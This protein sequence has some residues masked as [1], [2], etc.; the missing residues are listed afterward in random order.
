MNNQDPK[1]SNLIDIRNYLNQNKES[2]KNYFRESKAHSDQEYD[3]YSE[4]NSQY[5]E[6]QEYE[7]EENENYQNNY[8]NENND[9]NKSEQNKNITRDG[10]LNP[11]NNN[12]STPK[13]PG[14][15]EN[16]Q[17]DKI[18]LENSVK[19]ENELEFLEEQEKS[20]Q[21]KMK[22]NSEIDIHNSND[23]DNNEDKYADLEKKKQILLE[24][25][26]QKKEEQ[27]QL[28]KIAKMQEEDNIIYKLNENNSFGIKNTNNFIRNQSIKNENDNNYINDNNII[29]NK[30]KNIVN[31]VES[32]FQPLLYNNTKNEYTYQPKINEKSK[33]IVKEKGIKKYDKNNNTKKN[34]IRSTSSDR[35]TSNTETIEISLYNDNIKKLNKEEQIKKDIENNINLNARKIKM[36]KK[37]HYLASKDIENKIIKAIKKYEY[38][39]QITFI[40]IAYV[41]TELK[42]FRELLIPPKKNQTNDEIK[43]IKIKLKESKEEED[44][45]L[46]EE[47]RFIEQLWIILKGL[48]NKKTIS[49]EFFCDFVKLLFSPDDTT[50]K[51]TSEI[52]NKYLKTALFMEEGIVIRMNN[53]ISNQ[54]GNFNHLNILTEITQNYIS[55]QDIWPIPTL[56]KNFYN[57]KRNRIAY[58]SIRNLSKSAEK[59]KQK[60]EDN[61]TFKPKINNDSN[62]I[63]LF[64]KK[65]PN[66][67]E[68]EILKKK[69]LEKLKKLKEQSEIEEC[70]FHPII[71]KSKNDDSLLDKT[72]AYDKLYNKATDL[73]NKR[74]NKIEEQKI[75]NQK[76]ELSDCSFNPKLNK[77]EK[78][79]L[80]RS[81]TSKKKP[82]GYDKFVEIHRKGI[83]KRFEKKYLME[84]KP[85]GENFE[86]IK[87][88]NIQPF[89]ITDIRKAE[90][91]EFKKLCEKTNTPFEESEEESD[92]NDDYF[93]IEVLV[94]NGKKRILK[95]YEN[96]DPKEVAE[97]FCKT[98]SV[99]EDVKKKLI[100]NIIKFKKEYMKCND[101]ENEDEEED[102]NYEYNNNIM[103]QEL[104]N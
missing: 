44:N 30:K 2:Q 78:E 79:K 69:T 94:Q 45:R 22:K 23:I 104:Y 82:K 98:Y 87:R 42:I 93:T 18:Q 102:E 25:M 13:L 1:K 89:N 8:N 38:K 47:I 100:D 62:S 34:S 59:D 6:G 10:S 27:E 17:I 95:I 3:N 51:E 43:N 64:S 5:E 97:N 77:I 81:F 54:S 83:L 12:I 68:Q 4:N 32:Y 88:M 31:E 56:V 37:S 80:N 90:K 40:G 28:N 36:N 55:Y 53:N 50:I 29:I 39:D 57:L 66:Y 49:S 65:I 9:Y 71:N 46:K 15:N 91:E 96:D 33:R 63:I 24:K 70:T 75:L 103:T 48:N 20:R 19:S 26:R 21:E 58:V 76:K 52:L 72:P 14:N 73:L 61:L 92:G 41:F 85:I 16:I 11:F 86:K 67:E 84:K 35:L 60:I 74:R 7:E 99:K 101:K